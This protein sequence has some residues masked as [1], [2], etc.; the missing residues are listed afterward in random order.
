[1][2]ITVSTVTGLGYTFVDRPGFSSKLEKKLNLRLYAFSN[3][4]AREVTFQNSSDLELL[5]SAGTLPH[6]KGRLIAGGSGID[7]TEYYPQTRDSSESLLMRKQLGIPSNN[8]VVMFVGRLQLDK[9]IVEF[10][11]AARKLN[12][13]R[14]DISFVMVGAPDPGNKRTITEA[15]LNQWN[16][17]RD[18]IFTG[19][20]EDV[21]K[22][23]AIANTI[24]TP[25]FYCE[26]LPRTLLEAAASGLPLI[27]TDIPGV[28]DAISPGVNGILIPT[29]DSNALAKAIQDLADNPR[30]A[31]RYGNGSLNRAKMEFDHRLVVGE[32]LK[33]YDELWAKL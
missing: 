25:T 5:R 9:G 24:T 20:R 8:F 28:R 19:R 4:Q 21:P 2:P 17:E 26:G 1:M 11:Q 16:S 6:S 33:L 14:E 13:Q 18:V 12:K 27:G 29:R 3:R 22:L 10:V 32:Y 15:T 23:M 30:K 7:L 31:D